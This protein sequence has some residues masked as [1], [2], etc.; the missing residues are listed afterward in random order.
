MKLRLAPTLRTLARPLRTAHGEVR[1]RRGVQVSLEAG[2]I[3]GR[4]EASPM[5]SFGTETLE[6]SLAALQSFELESLP[7]VTDAIAPMLSGLEAVPA[8]RFAI[9]SVLLE[10]LALQ[11]AVPVAELLGEPAASVATGAL[12]DGA[13]LQELARA[14]VRAVA[15]GFETV[16]LKVGARP[17]AEDA[18]RVEAV[19]AAAGPGIALRLDANGAWTEHEART[20]LQSLGSL[21]I[22]LCEQP[23]PAADFAALRRLRGTVPCRLAAD[24]SLLVPGAV[25]ALLG[26][27]PAVDVL[28]LK[29]AALGGVLRALELARRA[30]HCGVSIYVTT[31][32]DGP[33]GTA[34]ALHL[35]AV[36]PAGLAH[37]LSTGTLFLEQ[38]PWRVEQGRLSLPRG[39][40]WGLP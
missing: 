31:L 23:V 32:L 12:L 14:A 39:P 21:E 36:L 13:D 24:E 2:G 28:V 10:H 40:G 27:R 5:P 9:E 17:L 4:G 7:E 29:P 25:D 8:A 11:R 20:A 37:G 18:A 15:E 35:A 30:E 3:V 19:R 34:A 22:E 33:L 6:Q 26:E 1:E 38:D 16:K